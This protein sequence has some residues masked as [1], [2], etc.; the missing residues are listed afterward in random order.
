MRIG[1][2]LKILFSDKCIKGE[3]QMVDWFFKIKDRRTSNFHS[4]GLFRL[5]SPAHTGFYTSSVIN[6]VE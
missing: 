6:V 3:I 1:I 4:S 5:L 2:K